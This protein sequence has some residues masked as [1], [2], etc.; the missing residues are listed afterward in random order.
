MR[1]S[2]RISGVDG[3]SLP[4]VDEVNG[5][6]RARIGT[7]TH[8]RECLDPTRPTTDGSRGDGREFEFTPSAHVPGVP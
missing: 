7:R 2:L 5:W 6:L 8:K 3:S 4:P 1:R